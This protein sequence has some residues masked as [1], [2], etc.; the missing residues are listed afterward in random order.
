VDL[1]G[2]GGQV[3]P[4]V[5]KSR[6]GEPHYLIIIPGEVGAESGWGGFREEKGASGKGG[7]RQVC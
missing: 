6:N 5:A 1:R 7:Y 4:L 3:K 2:G